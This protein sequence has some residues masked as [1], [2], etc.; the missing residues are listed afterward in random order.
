M[1][2]MIIEWTKIMKYFAFV[3][4]AFIMSISGQQNINEKCLL[5]I[6]LDSVMVDSSL[7]ENIRSFFEEDDGKTTLK[8]FDVD[9]NEDGQFEKFIPNEHLCGTGGCPWIIYDIKS[10]KL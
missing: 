2:G 6:S 9:L 4:L 10:N 8:S 3:F 7:G 1:F 5:Q